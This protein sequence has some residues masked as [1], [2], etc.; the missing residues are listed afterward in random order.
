MSQSCSKNATNTH[1]DDQTKCITLFLSRTLRSCL[2]APIP[3]ALK[4][5]RPTNRVLATSVGAWTLTNEVRMWFVWKN[6]WLQ[7]ASSVAA[8][9][10]VFPWPSL[11][12]R[13]FRRLGR[14]FPACP[15]ASSQSVSPVPL[16]STTGLASRCRGARDRDT[17][18]GPDSAS[19]PR[20]CP[21]ETGRH[22]T[23]DRPT[24]TTTTCISK[25]P[26]AVVRLCL[27]LSQER[28]RK[29]LSFPCS[30][31]LLETD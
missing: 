4:K 31:T 11:G 21:S 22:G 13:L 19:P 3:G 16:Q 2:L 17:A 12:T 30:G 6:S 15:A 26:C 14:E 25:R 1:V 8:V 18:T 29:R 10:V 28:K 5:L 9:S 23:V 20:P 27:S 24:S 7:I